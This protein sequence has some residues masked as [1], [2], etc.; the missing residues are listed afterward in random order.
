[1]AHLAA[2]DL[3][4]G[5]LPA[6]VEHAAAAR[7]IVDSRDLSDM[8]PMVVVYA[9]RRPGAGLGAVTWPESGRPSA[10]P[11]DSSTGWAICPPA[12]P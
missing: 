5:D 9:V 2:L 6:A 4:D 8:V 10:Q 3:D 12:P 1:M 7:S 11:S